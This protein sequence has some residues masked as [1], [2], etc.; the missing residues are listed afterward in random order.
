M[1]SK[2]R[3]VTQ[4]RRIHRGFEDARLCCLHLLDLLG[5]CPGPGTQLFARPG[6]FSCFNKTTPYLIYSASQLSPGNATSR[7]IASTRVGLL[8]STRNRL[9]WIDR[10]EVPGAITLSAKLL[11]A[12]ILQAADLRGGLCC[13]IQQPRFSFSSCPATVGF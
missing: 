4:V 7:L 6:P 8:T 3:Y 2:A 13:T 10:H 1:F 12:R 5:L 11:V 9:T